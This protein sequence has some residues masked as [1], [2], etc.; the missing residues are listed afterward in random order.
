MP[1]ALAD[2]DADSSED[3]RAAKEEAEE[4]EEDDDMDAD[5]LAR[6]NER[7]RQLQKQRNDMRRTFHISQEKYDKFRE[8]RRVRRPVLVQSAISV[9]GGAA[10]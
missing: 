2:M 5:A 9:L 8:S 10:H 7:L 3:E 4:E 6:A 1:G